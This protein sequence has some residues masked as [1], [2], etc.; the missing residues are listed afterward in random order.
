MAA[1]KPDVLV[2]DGA[3]YV[4]RAG[5]SLYVK[6]A[7]ICAMTDKSNQWI[8]QFV[9]QGTLNKRSTPHGLM[10]DL[11]SSIRAYCDMLEARTKANELKIDI[12]AEKKKLNADLV[13]KQSR[14]TMLGIKAKELQG[15]MH[16]SEDVAD[17]TED[18]IYNIRSMLLAL[19]GRLAVDAAAASDPAE[20]SEIV[21]K[22]VYSIMEELSKYRYDSKKYAERVRKRQNWESFG[23]E[24]D[25]GEVG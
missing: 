14:A 9:S 21:R 16:R 4:L 18:L 2:E 10:F 25:N 7:D 19:P 24:G 11:T 5:T 8:G 22:E 13:I 1:K 6:T 23:D 17:M 12:E 15:K 3:L 20:V